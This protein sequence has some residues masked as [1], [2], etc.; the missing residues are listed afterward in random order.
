MNL[1]TKE[2]IYKILIQLDRMKLP[3]KNYS[4]VQENGKLKLL[5]SGGSADVYEAKSR[6]SDKKN[7][8]IKVIGFRNQN[9][10][11]TEF[12]DSVWAQ[13][14]ICTFPSYVVKIYAHKE[15][16]ITFDEND[17]I[18]SAEKKKPVKLSRTS[19]KLQFIVMEKMIPVIKKNRNG[20]RNLIPEALEKGEEKEI[21]KLAYDIGTALKGAHHNKTLHR[22]I[23]LENVFY[24]EKKK[25]YKL[26]DFGIS[27][28]QSLQEA[29]SV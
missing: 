17:H 9:M 23:K 4:F 10:D 14:E 25:T 12:G 2:E 16:W 13:R 20:S 24:S 22:D 11:S 1:W 8:A 7:Y 18:V 3:F 21:L 19:L 29:A 6:I 5:G 26:G 28:K 27:K 15:L